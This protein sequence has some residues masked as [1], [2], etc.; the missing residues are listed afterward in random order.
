[1]EI[2]NSFEVPAPTEQVW[3]FLLDVPRVIPCMPGAELTQVID[4]R[5]WKGKVSVKLGPVKLAYA[6]TVVM[7][8]RDDAARRVVLK[9][10]GM[11]TGGKGMVSAVVT[12][13]LQPVQA[14][15]RVEIVTDLTIS[16]AAAQYGRGMIADVSAHFTE[17]F[18]RAMADQLRQEAPQPQT[19]AGTAAAAEPVSAAAPGAAAQPASMPS[20]AAQPPATTPATQPAVKPIAGLQLGL[21][22]LWRAFVRVCKRLWARLTGRPQAAE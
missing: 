4:E 10:K 1:V 17:Q 18:A 12:S 6:G 19:E 5:S 22:L 2:R 16:G 9:G 20:T 8:E 15:T 14:G 13:Q 3:T 21:W 11:E 7:E